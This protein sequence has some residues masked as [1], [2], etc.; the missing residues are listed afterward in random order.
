[1]LVYYRGSCGLTWTSRLFFSDRV[2]SGKWPGDEKI[3]K[4][5]G[6][7]GIRTSC[8]SYVL[9]QVSSFISIA[10]SILFFGVRNGVKSAGSSS[11]NVTQGEHRISKRITV[12][13]HRGLGTDNHSPIL[14]A[15]LGSQDLKPDLPQGSG[16]RPSPSLPRVFLVLEKE[17]YSFFSIRIS[18]KA[19]YQP[20]P[21]TSR[22]CSKS[23]DFS[24]L[25]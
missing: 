23:H 12:W 10:S 19:L 22:F 9:C 5:I 17:L 24:S 20:Q 15:E 3:K 16:P 25:G 13:V 4:N 6:K 18:G 2:S 11:D 1:M 8:I 14:W 7:F 21:W